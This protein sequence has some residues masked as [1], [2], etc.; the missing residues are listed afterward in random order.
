VLATLGAALRIRPV[1]HLVVTGGSI[2]EAVLSELATPVERDSIEWRRVHVWWGDER[3]V[4]ADSDDRNDKPAFAKLFDH[5]DVDPA[6][7]HRIPASDGRY[8]DAEAAAAAYA[9]ELASD[10]PPDRVEDSVPVF[11]VVLLGVGPDGH[12]AS[13]MP[14]HPGV[15]VEG[16]TVIAVRNSPKPPP[17]RLSFSFGTLD[18]AA[19]IWF[20]VAG[21][22]KAEAVA[23]AHS[24][25][26]RDQIPSAGPK[27]RQRTLWLVDRAAAALL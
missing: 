10:V 1:A 13:L 20:V 24:G 2:L 21:G 4:A 3:F 7:V 17:N 19:E 14:N 8:A 22:G 25:A 9:A 12:C 26:S 23:L 11:D 27:G 18:R 16:E 15:F 5:V 6:N